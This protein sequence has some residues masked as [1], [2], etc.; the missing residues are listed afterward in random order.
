[1]RLS[2][3]ATDAAAA[4]AGGHLAETQ[5]RVRQVLGE[6]SALAG[7]R[8]A[9]SRPKTIAGRRHQSAGVPELADINRLRALFDALGPQA[10]SDGLFDQCLAARAC[11]F[12][13]A[14]I[15]YQVLDDAAW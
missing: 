2:P 7:A 1:M 10:R 4:H 12:S 8:C 13:S 11:R 6:A 14:A 9:A 3:A 15:R 5:R